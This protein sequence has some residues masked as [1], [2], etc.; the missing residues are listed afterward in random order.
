[1]IKLFKEH[2]TALWHVMLEL[3]HALRALK[4]LSHADSQ[5]PPC[6]VQTALS[7]CNAQS[8]YLDHLTSEWKKPSYDI[9][10]RPSYH[11]L[12][13]LKELAL[14]P[15]RIASSRPA[16]KAYL[17][18]ALFVATSVVL[19]A[20]AST[21][22]ILF[23]VNYIPKVGVERIV[24][25]QYGSVPPLSPST[26]EW[27][28][29]FK[30]RDGPNPYALIPLSASLVPQQA[31]DITVQIDM[32]RSPPNLQLGNFMVDLVMLSPTY[33]TIVRPSAAEPF[34]ARSWIPAETILFS[35]RRPAI[36]TYHSDIVRVGKQIASLPSYLLG[37]RHEDE[38]LEVQMAEGVSFE[39]GRAKIPTKIYLDLQ[40]RGHDIQVYGV[41]LILRARFSGMRWL[42]YNH[43]I[44]AFIT[45]TGAFW[46]VEMTFA[47]LAL[48]VMQSAL[49]VSGEDN[50][51]VKVGPDDELLSAVKA[52]KGE[53]DLD[54]DDLDLSDTPRSFPTYGRQAPLQYIPKI[55][56]EEDSEGM[57]SDEVLT[58]PKAAEADDESE[59][60][61]GVGH[62]FGGRTDSGLGTS[63][64]E[65]GALSS[66]QRRKSKG[67]LG[68]L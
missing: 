49:G 33:K 19:F 63:Y 42:M 29:T 7:M 2:F 25:L 17:N 67:R 45:F 21:A 4:S 57:L 9:C 50:A 61:I 13:V 3:S 56:S 18:T 66:V 20:L 23:Y 36:L 62:A 52:E 46:V 44:L 15:V 68:A 58:H 51:K 30:T 27:R 26:F 22:Y 43:R 65:S 48:V 60:P 38:R 16:L 14:R 55:K 11:L 28:L 37:W 64:S 32:P 40:S 6:Q 34:D 1:M 24:H 39:K 35:S 54:M 12:T 41:K 53:N 10:S 59:D 5:V 8:V 31:Y 47:L